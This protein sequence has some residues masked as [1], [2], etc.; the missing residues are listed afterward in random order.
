M[1]KLSKYNYPSE[2]ASI[3]NPEIE[4]QVLARWN[5]LTKPPGSL[6]RLEAIVAQLA[7][8]QGTAAPRAGR[9]AMAIFCGDHGVAAE[10]VSAFPQ[11]VTVQMVRNFVNGGAAI[12]V[13]CR[14]FGIT[15][16]VVDT[17]VAGEHDPGA[18]DLRVAPGTNNLMR[19]AA[20]TVDQA[21]QALHN[22]AQ[23]AEAWSGKYDVAGA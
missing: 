8:I 10:G 23:L 18:L 16:V 7:A 15:P 1:P 19:E 21:G 4:R 11:E 22:G 13:L 17:G 12:S 9:K 5:S 3:E 6:G 20:M 2:I 14:Q